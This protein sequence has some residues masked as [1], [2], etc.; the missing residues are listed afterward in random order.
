M[1]HHTV[2]GA[3]NPEDMTDV[4]GGKLLDLPQDKRQRL[5]ERCRIKAAEDLSFDLFMMQVSVDWLGWCAPGAAGVKPTLKRL[6]DLIHLPIALAPPARLSDLLI[7]D[8]KEP[9]PD[10]RPPLE[11]GRRLDKGRERGLRD[12]FCLLGIEARAARR[13]EDLGEVGLDDGLNGGAITRPDLRR[14]VG[15]VDPE[16][17]TAC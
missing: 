7:Q 4:L 6:V 14:E 13:S 15:E 5:P 1:E 17:R 11:T 8:A 10:S 9:R 2:V 12:V 3:G 16:I